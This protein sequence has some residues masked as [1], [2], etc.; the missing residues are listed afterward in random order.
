MGQVQSSTTNRRLNLR[1]TPPAIAR[2]I[3]GDGIEEHRRARLGDIFSRA[4]GAIPE[5]KIFNDCRDDPILRFKKALIALSQTRLH[6]SRGVIV[7]SH[8]AAKT[9]L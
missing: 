4:T 7:M 6:V 5:T 1:P 3:D 2:Q 8:G 9:L